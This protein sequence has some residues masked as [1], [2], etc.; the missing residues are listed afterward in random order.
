MILGLGGQAG[1][2]K[3]TAAD[4]LVYRYGFKEVT[5]AAPLKEAA[6]ILYGLN[7]EQTNG[8]LKEKI[9]QRIGLAPREIM[10]RLG[11]ACRDIWP[12]VFV[13][14]LLQKIYLSAE[15]M[16]VVSDV[17]FLNEARALWRAGAVMLRLERPGA[18]ARNGVIGHVSEYEVEDWLGWDYRLE[19]GGT[20]EELYQKID[21]LMPPWL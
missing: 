5:F 3:S 1:S 2:G 16:F 17:R 14:S 4:Y 10:Q 20:R 13:E 9:D 11:D 7:P 19:N 21:N 6:G 8:A 18:A 15:R 12:I